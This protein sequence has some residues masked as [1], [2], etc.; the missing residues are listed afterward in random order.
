MRITIKKKSSERVKTKLKRKARIRKK[1][2]GTS[3]RPRLTVFRS[4]KHTYAQLIDDLTHKTIV[5]ASTVEKSFS[6]SGKS[7]IEAATAVGKLIAE[8]AQEKNIKNVVFD[9]SGYL[10]HGRISAIANSAREAG[11]K[12]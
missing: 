9:R 1:L 8:R 10:Y 3:E 5:S 11:L 7:N 12:F 4:G 6:G 2:S